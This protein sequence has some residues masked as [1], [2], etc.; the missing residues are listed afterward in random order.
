MFKYVVDEL[1]KGRTLNVDTT[2]SAIIS[3]VT[4][5]LIGCKINFIF[6]SEMKI[7][8]L[9]GAAR[10]GAALFGELRNAIFANVAHR[11]IRELAKRVFSHIHNLDLSFHLGR[12]T[13]ALSKAIDRGTK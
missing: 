8:C 9:D 6:L 12:Q 13:G 10:A 11:S 1:N 5:L 4:A 7:D 3:M 2:Q